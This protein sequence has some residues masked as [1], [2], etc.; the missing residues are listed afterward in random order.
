MLTT[1]QAADI[2]GVTDSHVRRLIIAGKLPAE[3][4]GPRM[5]VLKREDVEQYRDQHPRSKAGWPKGRRRKG[6]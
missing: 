4:V 5:L 1:K 3:R 6:E 2:L